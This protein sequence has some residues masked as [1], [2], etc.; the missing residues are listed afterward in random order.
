VILFHTTGVAFFYIF[1]TFVSLIL[2][3]SFLSI[4]MSMHLLL[5]VVLLQHAA[6]GQIMPSCRLTFGSNKYDLTRFSDLTLN[7]DG[8]TPDRYHYALNPCGLVPPTSCGTPAPPRTGA[9]ACQTSSA[10][11]FVSILAYIDGTKQTNASFTERQEPGT[12]VVMTVRNGDV[13]RDP[14][15]IMIVTFICDHKVKHPTS[16]NSDESPPCTF[17]IELK[18]ADACPVG[19]SDGSPSA[20]FGGGAI[21]VI[22]VVVIITVYLLV[23]VLWKR[24]KQ[25]YRGRETIPHRDFWANLL[26]LIVIG[27]RFSLSKVRCSSNSKYQSV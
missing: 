13:C 3:I 2:V 4:S 21:F 27:C 8:T 6:F 7:G 10:S 5:L 19:S 26:A 17:N 16:M 15:R 24:F 18:A 9:M 14:T 11:S 23:G 20:S 12:G 25:G 1:N 22:V